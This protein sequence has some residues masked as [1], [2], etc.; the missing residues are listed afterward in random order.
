MVREGLSE[1]GTFYQRPQKNKELTGR[2][3]ELRTSQ[4]K[5]LRVISDSSISSF[6]SPHHI[7][8]QI[9][10]GIHLTT[11]FNHCSLPPPLSSSSAS[12]HL[13]IIEISLPAVSLLLPVALAVSSP[14]ATRGIHFKFKLDYDTPSPKLSYSFPA[15][16]E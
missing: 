10:S 11:R 1:K 2:Y 3:W 14:T 8:Q 5:Q 4:V 15:F 6:H 13:W 9:P 12:S 7:H 16:S